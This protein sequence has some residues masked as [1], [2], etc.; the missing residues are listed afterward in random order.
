MWRVTAL[1]NQRLFLALFSRFAATEMFMRTCY[2]FKTDCFRAV[3]CPLLSLLR[4]LHLFICRVPGPD[5]T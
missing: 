5:T 3:L 1:R 2:L 4:I